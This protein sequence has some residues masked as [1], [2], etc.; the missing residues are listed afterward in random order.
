MDMVTVTV[1]DVKQK[2]QSF[3]PEWRIE[4]GIYGQMLPA[5]E[6]A[7]TEGA[8]QTQEALVG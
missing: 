3:W 5:K 8:N 6:G 2:L 1:N 7:E 4:A